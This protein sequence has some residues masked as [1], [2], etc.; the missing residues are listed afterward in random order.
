MGVELVAFELVQLVDI[1]G[2]RDNILHFEV[3]ANPQST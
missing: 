3:K 2:S 1:A